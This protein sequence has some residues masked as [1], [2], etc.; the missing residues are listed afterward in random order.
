MGNPNVAASAVSNADKLDGTDGNGTPLP[1]R[2]A[3]MFYTAHMF[4]LSKDYAF[5][6]GPNATASLLNHGTSLAKLLTRKQK[7]ADGNEYDLWDCV[8]TIAKSVVAANPHINDDE[9]LSVN[10]VPPV[11][12][13]RGF[14]SRLRRR[15]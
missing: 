3:A 7:L 5:P 15:Q 11:V 9:V 8:F 1:Y 6:E 14:L 4:G 2:I 12:S 10:Y 13:S